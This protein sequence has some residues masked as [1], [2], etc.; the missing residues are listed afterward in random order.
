[1]KEWV[2]SSLAFAG[3]G[4]T[5]SF[6]VI[7]MLFHPSTSMSTLTPIYLIGLFTGAVYGGIKKGGYASGVAFILGLTITV[8]LNY[9]WMY[10]P[11]TLAYSLAFLG[12]V[13]VGMFM[14]E[15]KSNLDIGMIPFSYFG[16]FILGMLLFMNTH[17]GEIEGAAMSVMLTGVAG[18]FV[19][20]FINLIR[21]FFGMFREGIKGNI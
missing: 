13:I 2:L 18:A 11:L 10:K 17:L 7:V 6:L 14:V 4:I 9:L 20:F 3:L 5:V 1:M 16:G 12:I 15:G 19:A 21:V 8:L